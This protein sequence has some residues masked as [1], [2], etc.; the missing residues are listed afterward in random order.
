MPTA[1]DAAK[2][3]KKARQAET[4][5][6]GHPAA[7]AHTRQLREQQEAEFHGPTTAMLD[8][9]QPF[10]IEGGEGQVHQ[11]A[12]RH[13]QVAIKQALEDAGKHLLKAGDIRPLVR[14]HPWWFVGGAVALGA[15]AAGAVAVAARHK[16]RPLREGRRARDWALKQ[17]ME[18]ELPPRRP[19]GKRRTLG[20]VLQVGWRL[21]R[22]AVFAIL[23]GA[24]A[25][26]T[27]RAGSASVDGA[28]GAA[29]AAAAGSGDPFKP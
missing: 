14:K 9:M 28:A 2:Q 16:D 19:G 5:H 3:L 20:R 21:T 17:A 7:E 13:A 4:D 6:A 27:S 15:A 1:S 18:A 11:M 25:Q 26:A 24:I 22:P 29:A 10:N 23:S 12:A 8:A